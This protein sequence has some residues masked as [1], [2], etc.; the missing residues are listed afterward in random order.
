MTEI[1]ASDSE[2]LSMK[3]YQST[4]QVL[5]IGHAKTKNKTET[6]ILMLQPKAWKHNE[7]VLCSFNFWEPNDELNA[8]INMTE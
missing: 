3:F 6:F 1:N 5:S 7:Y 2:D 4:F 8:D